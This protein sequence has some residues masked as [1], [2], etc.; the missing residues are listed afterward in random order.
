MQQYISPAK[1]VSM[2][3]QVPRE[4]YEPLHVRSMDETM[5]AQPLILS[6]CSEPLPYA[7]VM[8]VRAIC[9]TVKR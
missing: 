7:S 2:R 6:V 8:P 9:K 3:T 4:I 1:A 5:R